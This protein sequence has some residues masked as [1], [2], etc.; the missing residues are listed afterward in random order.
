[1]KSSCTLGFDLPPLLTRI[2]LTATSKWI[3][4]FTTYLRR[5]W[6]LASGFLQRK[7]WSRTKESIE[8]HPFSIATT[9]SWRC[10][11]YSRSFMVRVMLV[12]VL[13]LLYEMSLAWFLEA[14]TWL[15]VVLISSICANALSLLV[16]QYLVTLL[17]PRFL[18][19]LYYY[20]K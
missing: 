16:R 6:L 19:P 1:M 8:H 10:R 15:R 3:L 2:C 5:G 14:N 13:H 12:M 7:L 11:G 18:W 4:L 9:R 17:L 20:F